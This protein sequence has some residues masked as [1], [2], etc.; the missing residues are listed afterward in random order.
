MITFTPTNYVQDMYLVIQVPNE[1]K[2]SSKVTCEALNGVS[3]DVS[4][5]VLGR[6]ITVKKAF[7]G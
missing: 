4:C 2:I 7:P 6:N 5:E 1:L 3:S